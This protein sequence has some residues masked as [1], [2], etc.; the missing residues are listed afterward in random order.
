MIDSLTSLAKKAD[1]L[2]ER[3]ATAEEAGND[4]QVKE[5][6]ETFERL[7]REIDARDELMRYEYELVEVE[8]MISGAEREEDE[9][10]LEILERVHHGL[11]RIRTLSEQLLP[12]QLD[13]PESAAQPL[14]KEKAETFTNQVEKGFRALQILEEIYEAEEEEDEALLE[15]LEAKYNELRK[16]IDSDSGGAE[17]DEKPK[18]VVEELLPVV[19]NEETL[20]PFAN[21]NLQRDVAPLLEQYCFDCHGNDSS[22]GELNLQKLLAESPIVRNRDQWINVHRAVEESRD[23]SRR[24]HTTQH[25]GARE[26]RAVAAQRNL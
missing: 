9:E 10:R 22:S 13:G 14:E 15:E 25:G 20:A 7:Q 19:V 11:V 16:H 24:R 4:A 17:Q 8:E 3:I 2:E 6:V 1:D 12:I 26:N 21:A 23:A 18:A 5:L